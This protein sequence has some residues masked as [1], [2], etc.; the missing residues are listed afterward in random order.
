MRPLVLAALLIAMILQPAAADGLSSVRWEYRPL[1]IFTPANDD[2]RL[3]RQTTILA[4]ESAGLL[5]RRIAVYIVERSRVYTTFGAPA[6]RAE[7]KL[8]RRRFRVPDDAFRVVLIG[9]DGGSKLSSEE[10]LTGER[11]FSVIDAM[12]MRQRELRDRAGR[13]G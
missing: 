12:P 7:A 11:L 6:P 9:L 2:A 5:D 8:L 3:S 10:P 13:E 1:L 4:D